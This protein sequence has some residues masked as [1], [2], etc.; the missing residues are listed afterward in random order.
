[1]KIAAVADVHVG[2]HKVFGKPTYAGVNRRCKLVLETLAYALTEA[3]NRKAEVFL[4]CGDLADST[5]MAPQ[6]YAQ[7]QRLFNTA[8][9]GGLRVVLLKGN[10]EVVS[11][12]EGDHALGPLQLVADIVEN[13]CTLSTDTGGELVLVPHQ[14]GPAR[15]WLDASVAEALSQGTSTL[16]GG[17]RTVQSPHRLRQPRVLALHLGISDSRTAPWLRGAND[18]I[19]VEALT[20]ICVKHSIEYVLAG[21]W[22]DRRSWHTAARILQIGALAPTGFDNSGLDGYGRVA[23]LDTSAGG[24][25]EEV[26]VPSPRFVQI[27]PD[28]PDPD[29]LLEHCKL[30]AQGGHH[31]FLE[32]TADRE[33][34]EAWAKRLEDI[35]WL[36]GARIMPDGKE[37]SRTARSAARTAASA[38]TLSAAIAGY[39]QKLE[40]ADGVDRAD[41][42]ARS[43]K[44]LNK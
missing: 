35:D 25:F 34:R 38:D 7:V 27:K 24:S 23:F 40:V 31:V 6:I 15:S 5:H 28:T 20:E 17:S 39:V 14:A 41:V 26:P 36:A 11:H 19:Q 2:N 10:H 37:A 42:T 13:P 43:H 30:A 16:G 18:S 3:I 44:Y 29:T 33:G 1:M 12:T 22:H 8:K 32:V 4:V 21:N 9:K